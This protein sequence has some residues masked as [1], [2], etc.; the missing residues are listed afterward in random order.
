ML[1]SIPTA[2]HDIAL[3]QLMDQFIANFLVE[4]LQRTRPLVDHG[5]LH[6]QGR[7]HRSVF[8]S[9][10]ASPDHR[11]GARELLQ[12]QDVIGSDDGLTIRLNTLWFTRVC[13]DR[14][15]NVIGG[16]K[17]VAMHGID[18]YRMW[19]HKG[20]E[21]MVQFDVIASER[22]TDD[23]HFTLH[24]TSDVAEKLRHRGTHPWGIHIGVRPVELGLGI[25]TA[26]R[27]AKGFG[28]N[29]PRFDA[30][31]TDTLLFFDHNSFFPQFRG[32]NR[33]PFVPLDHCQCK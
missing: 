6:T 21:P 28:G 22:V 17:T 7:K 13:P 32:L 11:H 3:A 8:N 20:G 29:R 27:L 23:L 26:Y 2:K 25:Q 10:D 18:A 1:N 31:T 14:K 4:K 30:G 12:G 24:H 5:H 16:E 19:F 33:R 9:N 15:H